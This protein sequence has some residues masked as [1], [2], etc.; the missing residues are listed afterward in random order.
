MANAPK[1]AAAFIHQ[2]LHTQDDGSVVT[3]IACRIL[4]PERYASRHLANIGNEVHI[5][6]FFGIFMQDPKDPEEVYYGVS[7]TTAMIRITPGSTEKVMV[8]GVSYYEFHFFPGDRVFPTTD[9]VRNDILTYHIYDEHVAKGNVPWYFNYFDLGQLLSTAELHA[10][11]NLGNKAV[12]ELIISTMCRDKTDMTRL[13]RHIYT[14]HADVVN[15]P[16][17]IIPFRSVLWNTSDTTSKLIGA[18]FGDS[19]TSALVNPSERTERIEEL[20]RT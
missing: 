19:I 17:V 1:R 20:L 11:I 3:D 2:H 18:Y 7:V 15:N 16:P 13:Y 8:D 9:L 5:L 14:Q 6:G 12:P 4:V 10:G